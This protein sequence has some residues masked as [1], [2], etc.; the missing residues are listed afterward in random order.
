MQ[1]VTGRMYVAGMYVRGWLTRRQILKKNPDSVCP[2]V[3]MIKVKCSSAS[4]LDL[5]T[6]RQDR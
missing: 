4:Q 5:P 1:E 6:N 2:S 3:C